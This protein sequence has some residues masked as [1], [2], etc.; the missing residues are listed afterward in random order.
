MVRMRC[1]KESSFSKAS[2]S[3]FFPAL[4][5]RITTVGTLVLPFSA[6]G[7]GGNGDD[8]GDVSSSGASSVE[9]MFIAHG[10]LMNA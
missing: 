6:G 7:G 3:L 1:F 10:D 4:L 2:A 8:G 9:L 5:V